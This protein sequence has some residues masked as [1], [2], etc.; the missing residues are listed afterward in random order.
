MR[1][2]VLG[3]LTVTEG[4]RAIAIGGPRQRAVLAFLVLHANQVMS[5]D[6][7]VDGLWGVPAPA[8][9]G[10]ALQ[11]AISRLRK[12][13]PG[14]RLM[15]T[16]HGY[17][18]RVTADELDLS[19]FE[20]AFA[21][22]TQALTAGAPHDAAVILRSALAL[23]RGPALVDFR[24]EPFAQGEIAR[25]EEA[26]LGC[27]E[28][29]I[30][31]DLALGGG[32]DLIAELT[33]LVA[34]HPL[35]ET[36]TG[37]LM[38]A[39]YRSGRQA[40]ALEAYRS[41]R[42]LLADE[43]GIDP[44][45]ALVRLETA[46]LRQE[47]WLDAPGPPGPAAASS[48]APAPAR[49]FAGEPPPAS[50]PGA[51]QTP[52]AAGVARRDAARRDMARREPAGFAGGTGVP[53]VAS[54]RRPVTV[55]CLDVGGSAAA[56]PGGFGG[57]G[58]Y[59]T[60]LDPEMLLVVGER[61][62]GVVG[63][64][65][66]RHGGRLIPAPGQRLLGVLGAT[67][68]HE[69]DA[70]RGAAAALE[71]R[72]AVLALLAPA[73]GTDGALSCRVG[74]ATAEA[75]VSA[76]DP[77]AVAVAG[78]AVAQAQRL[79]ESAAP[80][81][82]L[83]SDRTYRLAAAAL[84]VEAPPPGEGVDRH[85]LLAVRFGERS[86]PVRLEAPVLGRAE[87][88]RRI[89]QAGALARERRS[90]AFVT[91]VGDAGTGKTRL[92]HELGARLGDGALVVTGRCLP[93]GEGVT[94]WPLRGLVEQ[95]TGGGGS[96]AEVARVLAGEPDAAVVADRLTRAF[97]AGEAGTSD[98]A[99]IFWATRRLFEAAAR[100]RLLVV[101]L[102]DLHW[103]EPT[104]LELVESVALQPTSG[105]VLVLA[106]TRP[107]LLEDRPDWLAAAAA[108]V[109]VPLPPLDDAAMAA[110]ADE[111]A[112]P[113]VLAPE[114]RARLVRAAGGNPLY[115]EQLVAAA[116]EQGGG[117][118]VGDSPVPPTIQALLAS[119]L[120]RLGPAE[121]EVL[122]AAAVVG[123]DFGTAAVAALLP[124]GIGDRL[125]WHLRTLTTKALVQ[126]QPP[127]ADQHSFRHILVQQA[128]Y[129]AIP[130]AARATLHER[131]ADWAETAPRPA[132]RQGDGDSQ[133]VEILGHHLSQATSYYRELAQT[134]RAETLAG[135]AAVYLQ[136]A[137]Q[138]SLAVGDAAAAVR[139]F[140]RTLTLLRPDD[141]ERADVLAGL[142][143]A[144]VESG[145]LTEARAVLDQARRVAL[146]GGQDRARAHVHVQS[147]Q[148]DLHL[149]PGGA[150]EKV[151]QALPDVR[152]ALA[153][154]VAGLARAWLLEATVHWHRARSAAA[155]QAWERAA[156]A[157]RAAGDRRH[158]AQSLWWLASGALWGPTPARE[159]IARCREYLREMGSSPTGQG[160]VQ[161]HLAGLHAMSDDLPTAR[162]LRAR[163]TATLQD[164]GST[165]PIVLAEP[166]AFIAVLVEDFAA[167]EGH[168]LGAF[169]ALRRMGE[170]ADLATC[171]A[172]LA[173]VVALQGSDAAGVPAPGFTRWDEVA[174]HVGTSRT[175]AGGQDLTARI[176]GQGALARADVARGRAD[177]ALALAAEAVELAARTDLVNQHGDA[178]V[179]RAA[180]LRAAGHEDDALAAARQ[181]RSLYLGK[182]NVLAARQCDRFLAG[183][184]Q[185]VT[186]WANAATFRSEQGPSAEVR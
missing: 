13:L 166:A 89:E 54:S 70:Q 33:R 36:L 72:D 74:V 124:S 11:A 10:N 80:G 170:Q 1:I 21:R 102:E 141:G 146:E 99:E 51:P 53:V 34:E 153:G 186:D 134:E 15:T 27:R 73:D 63:P 83:V 104:F 173:R 174:E 137:G 28:A 100:E 168:L 106:V 109:V 143:E 82:V 165:L 140:E 60:G 98:T 132:G 131:L 5:S 184:D 81:Q 94:F 136:Q 48:H 65:L 12:V 66:E 144:L 76:A 158:L 115:L 92:V 64:A 49:T 22:G 2:A 116:D 19:E 55:V 88:L 41:T 38:L 160:V 164:V 156:A 23:W 71:A 95:L 142:G 117:W 162:A 178:L 121:H 111:L 138:S 87:E 147:L 75:L 44:S 9:A 123:K 45:A 169:E 110:L 20:Q 151:E 26:R 78:E 167:A 18:L 133:R 114:A 181:A 79:A 152:A 154:D 183:A 30:E 39:L 77:L 148:L 176:I 118:T 52:D 180:V 42:D 113:G 120:H 40:E 101:V 171:A 155:E 68:L 24:F 7:L 157:A 91:V 46:M 112:R 107:E 135:R 185:P 47:R 126:A 103:A 50:A 69:D 128:T 150:V 145:R 14:G 59:G 139:A 37:Q 43:L 16:P 127:T 86:L 58:G 90:T 105:P 97:G 125:P 119:R 179:D 130:K 25:L 159:G 32:A 6:R 172:M 67:T 163:G 177:S 108:H 17:L 96:P 129:R 161:L 93:Y 35:R 3:P 4:G 61:V 175:S 57:F 29:R 85:V 122:A 8:A 149:D 182:G 31:A 56:A 84:T 62:R